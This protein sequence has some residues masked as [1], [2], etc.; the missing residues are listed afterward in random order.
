LE[1][2][3]YSCGWISDIISAIMCFYRNAIFL[4]LMIV[5]EDISFVVVGDFVA[6]ERGLCF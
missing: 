3:F 5:D 4:L 2:G 6:K 1:I